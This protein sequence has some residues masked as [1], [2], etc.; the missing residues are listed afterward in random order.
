M[1]AFVERHISRMYVFAWWSAQARTQP[2]P[3]GS[4]SRN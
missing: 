2:S 3:N 1:S 4:G